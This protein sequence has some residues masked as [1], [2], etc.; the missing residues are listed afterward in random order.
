VV[1]G[2][3]KVLCPSIE[4]QGQKAGVS[5]LEVQWDVGED[6]GFSEVKLGKRITFEMY[7]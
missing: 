6:R 1:L 3:V 4:C 5:G 7:I 2:P